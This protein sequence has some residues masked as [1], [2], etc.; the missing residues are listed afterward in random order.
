MI[1]SC[2]EESESLTCGCGGPTEITVPTDFFAEVPF[3]VQTSGVIFFKDDDIIER[4]VPDNRWEEKFWI[5][6]GGCTSC[7][8]K[9]I[10]CNENI[11][12]SQFDFLKEENNSDSIPIKFE[13]NLMIPCG[14]NPFIAPADIFYAEI[15]LTS[16]KKAN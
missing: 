16:I 12:G 9:L 11:L 1:S 6:Q 8:R 14:D 5:I 2:N 4:Y 7:E 3:E 10:V 13:G 15:V